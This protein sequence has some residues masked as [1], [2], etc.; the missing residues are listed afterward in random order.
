ME[1]NASKPLMMSFDEFQRRQ[2]NRQEA[3]KPPTPKITKTPNVNL[4]DIPPYRRPEQDQ[5]ELDVARTLWG[6]TRGE[7]PKHPDLNKLAV[8][9]ALHTMRNRATRSHLE[10]RIP[11]KGKNPKIWRPNKWP[12]RLHQVVKQPYQYSV[13]NPKDENRPKMLKLNKGSP[14]LK[15]IYEVMNDET[16]LSEYI[17]HIKGADHYYSDK[18]KN[19]PD[20]RNRLNFLGTVGRHRF[21]KE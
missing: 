11:E 10:K 15:S 19:P 14:E 18:M 6:E 7:F 1:N 21:Y 4:E 12:E 5:E 20:W 3:P 17:Q 8:R 16:P 2:A 9:A 13:W